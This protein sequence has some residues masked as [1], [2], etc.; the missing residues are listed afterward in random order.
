MKDI[1]LDMMK[2]WEEEQSKLF[3]DIS[4]DEMRE[5]TTVGDRQLSE[6]Y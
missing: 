5:L 6:W 2:R 4:I 3:E 1:P